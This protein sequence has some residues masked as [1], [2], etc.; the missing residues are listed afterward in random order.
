ML[1]LR[2]KYSRGYTFGSSYI[3]TQLWSISVRTHTRISHS[4]S[5]IDL[6]FTNQ[7]KL[8]VNCSTHSTLNTE[9]HPRIAHCKLNLNIEYSPLYDRPVWDSKTANNRSIKK[10]IESVNWKALF[11]NKTIDNEVSICSETVINIFS[12]FVPN[13]LVTFD[14]NGPPWM[15]NFI[16]NKTKWKLLL[17]K[18][19]VQVLKFTL[20][21]LLIVKPF[22]SRWKICS[23]LVAE[24]TYCKKS[25]VTRCEIRSLLVATNHLLFVAEVAQCKMSFV[26]C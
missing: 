16:K 14:E 5:C 24:V 3:L 17:H 11:N 15:N 19:E 4:C 12:N 6:I 8:E 20:G 25:H 2:Q 22:V 23:L 7:P 26:T 9:R 1:D 21:S 13:K 18:V 10:S